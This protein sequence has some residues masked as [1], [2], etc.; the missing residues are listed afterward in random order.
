MEDAMVRLS[1]ELHIKL[2]SLTPVFEAAAKD[3]KSLYYPFDTH[4]NSTG[5][6]IAAA[7]MTS[8]LRKEVELQRRHPD[9]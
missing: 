7:F 4:W 2:A 8:V 5:R 6:E 3:G 9:I 1:S